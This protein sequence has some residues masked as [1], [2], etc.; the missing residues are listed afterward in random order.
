MFIHCY[1]PSRNVLEGPHFMAYLMIY[2]FPMCFI[3]ASLA[4]I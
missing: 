3:E 1:I 2:L 4:L